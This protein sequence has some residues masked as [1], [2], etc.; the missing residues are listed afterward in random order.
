MASRRSPP[1]PRPPPLPAR[2][3]PLFGPEVDTRTAEDFAHEEI[4]RL[5]RLL[6]AKGWEECSSLERAILVTYIKARALGML[7]ERPVENKTE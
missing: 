6:K 7:E 5:D 2:G 1:I 4:R 3:S